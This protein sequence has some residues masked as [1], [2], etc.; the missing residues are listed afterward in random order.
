[1]STHTSRF[2]HSLPLGSATDRLAGTTMGTYLLI[3]LGAVTALTL[4]A[5]A[6]GGWPTCDGYWIDPFT[7]LAR[8][9][10]WSLLAVVADTAIL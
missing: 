10:A 9:I 1:M 2:A 5:S 4:A 3:V 8:T 6:C 7:D